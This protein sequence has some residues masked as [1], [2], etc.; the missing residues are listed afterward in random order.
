VISVAGG[1]TMT[2]VGVT[3]SSLTGDWIGTSS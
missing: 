3:L 2:L 1:A